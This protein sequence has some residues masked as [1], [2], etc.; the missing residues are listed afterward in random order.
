MWKAADGL[1]HS[2]PCGD[3]LLISGNPKTAY[4]L[5]TAQHH[6]FLFCQGAGEEITDNRSEKHPPDWVVCTCHYRLPCGRASGYDSRN[7]SLLV[8]REEQIPPKRL[9]RRCPLLTL[10]WHHNRFQ[11]ANTRRACPRDAAILLKD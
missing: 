9:I 2:S 10:M 8:S 4:H 11:T 5:S 1:P 7:K 3:E 6:I